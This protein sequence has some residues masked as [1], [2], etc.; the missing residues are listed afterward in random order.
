MDNKDSATIAAPGEKNKNEVIELLSSDDEESDNDKK[1]AAA[2]KPKPPR[3][4][5]EDRSIVRL[6][7]PPAGARYKIRNER[8]PRKKITKNKSAARL[9]LQA[10]LVLEEDVEECVRENERFHQIL[11]NAASAKEKNSSDDE[12]N[13]SRNDWTLVSYTKH[14]EERKQQGKPVELFHDLEFESTPAS[15]EGQA[16]QNKVEKCCCTVAQGSAQPVALSYI[17]RGPNKGRPYHHCPKSI[18]SARCKYFRWAF[19]AERMHWYRFGS[20]TG[21]VLVRDQG[22]SA[23][24]LLQ[25]RVGDCWFLS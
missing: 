23:D 15:I 22:F 9:P 6:P 8:G 5:Q 14:Q 21:H 20:H 3:R 11:Q 10:G 17:S 24:D 16:R 1:P 19:Q 13:A 12:D 25:G 4:C 2:G 7:L 18:K